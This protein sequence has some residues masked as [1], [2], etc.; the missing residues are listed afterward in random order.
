M[1]I[2]WKSWWPLI[3]WSGVIFTLSSIPYLKIPKIGLGYEDKIYHSIE[4]FIWGMIFIWRSGKAAP[5]KTA[6]A[7]PVN[8]LIEKIFLMLL[9]GIIFAFVDEFHQKWIPGRGFD[10]YDLFADIIG[11][12]VSLAVCVALKK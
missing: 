1:E 2:F 6:L 3:V 12:T 7:P 10:R 4:F 5:V 9:V 11:L 8:P